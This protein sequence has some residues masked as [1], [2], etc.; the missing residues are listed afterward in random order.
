MKASGKTIGS[1]IVR[2]K[3]FPKP[4][5]AAY[6]SFSEHVEWGEKDEKC[7][8]EYVGKLSKVSIVSKLYAPL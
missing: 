3:T 6:F 4:T 1:F 8:G 2:I 7:K 5:N